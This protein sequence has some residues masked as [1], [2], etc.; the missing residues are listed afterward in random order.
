MIS[1]PDVSNWEEKFWYNTGGTRAKKYL[2]KP[3]GGLFY[4]K[5]S[6]EK[7]ATETKPGKYFRFEFWS[8]IIAYQVGA[9]L[10]FDVLEYRPAIDGQYVGC[11]CEE[12]IDVSKGE[13]IAGFQYLQ[14]LK[15]DFDPEK[16]EN[17]CQYTFQFIEAALTKYDLERFM[18]RILEMIVFDALIGNTDRHQENWAIIS[19]YT[20][21]DK[22]VAQIEIAEGELD[23]EIK[24]GFK[25][26]WSYLNSWRLIDKPERRIQESRLRA[27]EKNF[28]PLFDNGSSLGRELEDTR[29]LQ[30]IRDNNALEK[31]VSRGHSCIHWKEEKV[32]HFT[33]IEK[34]M[35]TVYA[36]PLKEIISRTA[37]RFD[38]T[39]IK[40][41]VMEVDIAIPDTHK[42]YKIPEARKELIFKLITSRFQKLATFTNE[43]V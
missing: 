33:L 8:E 5:R 43:R 41:I 42:D 23:K 6:M 26:L 13:L 28:S 18:P 38:S 11:L 29:V 36:Q 4:F 19:D 39:K 9:L 35:E 34:L 24:S 10:G 12:M 30:Y 27:G 37:A 25:K 31:Y 21:F 40:S 14:G 2:E 17:R 1:V 22:E 32:S 7:A 20:F 16:N 3:D 15:P